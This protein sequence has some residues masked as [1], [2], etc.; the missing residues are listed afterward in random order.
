MAGGFPVGE[1]I[2][3]YLSDK[4]SRFGPPLLLKRD[5]GGNMNHSA[6]ND[7]LA[8]FFI[9]PLNSPAYYAPYN[10]A[11]EESQREMKRCLREKLGLKLTDEKREILAALK[12]A[13][14]DR[15][16]SFTDGYKALPRIAKATYSDKLKNLACE[17]WI[18]PTGD[19]YYLKPEAL[20]HLLISS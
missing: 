10:G 1:E 11:I 5:N 15:I 8:E 13:F 20:G 19:G 18:E 7:V 14:G 16:W 17:G 3:G 6:V 9:L 4:F 12:D 2:A